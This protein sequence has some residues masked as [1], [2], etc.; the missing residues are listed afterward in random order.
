MSLS[1]AELF[2]IFVASMT[3]FSAAGAVEFVV[4][5]FLF[6]AFLLSVLIFVATFGVILAE[7]GRVEL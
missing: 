6:V 7:A 5:P 3:F 4:V 1:L 2:V